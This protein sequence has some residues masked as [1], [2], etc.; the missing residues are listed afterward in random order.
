MDLA[1]RLRQSIGRFVR[2]TRARAD[3]LPPP[4]A[5]TLGWLS[6]SG[7]LTIAALAS[8]RGVRHQSMSRTVGELEELGYVS[9]AVNPA[10]GRGFVI[11]VAAAGAQALDAD[12]TARREWVA[13]AIATR[14]SPDEQRVLSA[15][16]ALLDRIAG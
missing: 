16:P 12:R 1:E 2:A 8:L 14:L 10:D 5:E 3:S 11:T 7:P 15:V 9:R 4:Q 6:R 13:E